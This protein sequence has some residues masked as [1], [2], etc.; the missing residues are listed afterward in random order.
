[1]F[2]LFQIVYL[3][4]TAVI[5]VLP[6]IAKPVETGIGMAMILSAVPVYIVFIAWK[7]KPKFISRVTDA[8]TTVVQKLMIV[9][10]PPKEQ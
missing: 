2:I 4:L 6:M 9:V 7:S 5:T 3:I 1:M 10:P 8:I